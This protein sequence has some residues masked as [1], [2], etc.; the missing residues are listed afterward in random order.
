MTE[1]EAWAI[2]I[3]LANY[4]VGTCTS[5]V[6][7]CESLE[8]DE[9]VENDKNFCCKFDELCFLCSTCGWWFAPEDLNDG[10]ICDDCQ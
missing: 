9:G 10:D 2:A 7:A 8:I 6:Q 5:F 1:A 4:L 3:R